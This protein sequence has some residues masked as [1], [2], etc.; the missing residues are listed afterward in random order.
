M[1]PRG[2]RS[3]SSVVAP[4]YEVELGVPESLISRL[5]IADDTGRRIT[6][7]RNRRPFS[8]TGEITESIDGRQLPPSSRSSCASTRII[9]HLRSGL[10]A[11]VTFQFSTSTVAD[12]FRPAAVRGRQRSGRRLRLHR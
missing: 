2:S 9:R 8:F 6:L 11:D 1:C 4:T 12:T 7:R 5:S 10:A 3:A